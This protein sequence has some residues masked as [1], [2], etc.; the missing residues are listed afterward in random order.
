MHHRGRR[1]AGTHRPAVSGVLTDQ[2]QTAGGDSGPGYHRKHYRTTH[3][4]SSGGPLSAPTSL[5][6]HDHLADVVGN[7]S[8]AG[9]P[10]VSCMRHHGQ[11]EPRATRSN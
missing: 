2:G 5:A 1:F 7:V 10:L 11:I 4:N 8:E 9:I 3:T 6:L